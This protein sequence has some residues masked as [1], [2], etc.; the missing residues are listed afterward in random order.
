MSMTPPE[1]VSPLSEPE[2]HLHRRL[3]ER[4]RVV[5]KAIESD[6]TPQAIMAQE[7]NERSMEDYTKPSIE[8]YGNGIN[9]LKSTRTSKLNLVQFIWLKIPFNSMDS[10]MKILILIVLDSCEF[11]QLSK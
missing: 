7:G 2:C 10:K 11:A 4:T 3:R 8:N 6:T 1:I 9:N 5:A